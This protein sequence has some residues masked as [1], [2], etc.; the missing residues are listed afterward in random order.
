[1]VIWRRTV[2]SPTRVWH[3]TLAANVFIESFCTP[4]TTSDDTTLLSFLFEF[5]Y[6]VEICTLTSTS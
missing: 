1:M 3:S 6:F 2:S 4:V 5:L